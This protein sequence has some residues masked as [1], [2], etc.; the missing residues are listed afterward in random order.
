[1]RPTNTNKEGCVPISSNCVN[2]Q[3]PNIDFLELCRNSSVTEVIIQLADKTNEI[4]DLLDIEKIDLACLNSKCGP[5][6]IRELIQA[7]IEKLCSIDP[8]A[9]P[10]YKEAKVNIPSCMQ[11]LFPD[12]EGGYVKQVSV[13]SMVTK[14]GDLYCSL[15]KKINDDEANIKSLKRSLISLEEETEKLGLAKQDKITVEKNCFD[16]DTPEGLLNAVTKALCEYKTA[17]GT[18]EKLTEAAKRQCE[19][20][21]STQTFRNPEIKYNQLEGWNNK[22]QTIAESFSNLWLTVCDIRY[23]LG[24]IDSSIPIYG[25][26]FD[27]V[28]RSCD[29]QL[30]MNISST[31][32]VTWSDSAT[33]TVTNGTNT[34][35]A[36]ISDLN[37]KLTSTN[38]SVF[39]VDI[40]TIPFTDN[41]TIT[42]TASYT[43]PG[44]SQSQQED[45]SCICTPFISELSVTKV[46]DEMKVNVT[47]TKE[48]RDEI[49]IFRSVNGGTAILVETIGV[50]DAG[51]YTDTDISSGNTYEYIL[52]NTNTS[53]MSESISI[54]SATCTSITSDAELDLVDDSYPNYVPGDEYGD[55]QIES[56]KWSRRYYKDKENNQ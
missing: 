47:F 14:L 31:D 30:R 10:E 3:G 22:P 56:P 43:K 33:L 48:N 18:A 6:D 53:C 29:G 40:A 15:S 8:N 9:S 45:W 17:L 54:A 20:L 19:N 12:G 28:W 36:N 46:V 39:A 42:L 25:I 41:L 44:L 49:E 13:S 16:E 21:D 27:N 5:K 35:T 2:W 37:T 32:N 1:M 7:I 26:R 11:S 24:S 38:P 23:K 50:N 52:Y 34:V 55:P 51:S 4:F